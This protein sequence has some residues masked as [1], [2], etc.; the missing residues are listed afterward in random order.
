MKKIEIITKEDRTI[1]QVGFDD[2]IRMDMQ[3]KIKQLYRF[4]SPKEDF[5]K[6]YPFHIDQ[7]SDW[8]DV[9]DWES[10]SSNKGVKWSDEL[11]RRFKDKWHWCNLWLNES[12]LCW[13]I[14]LLEEFEDEI[15]WDF[16]LNTSIEWNKELHERFEKYLKSSLYEYDNIVKHT[17]DNRKKFLSNPNIN[18]SDNFMELYLYAK[19]IDD[20]EGIFI[21]YDA[22]EIYFDSII[23]D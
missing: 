19:S 4:Y 14:K 2:D 20:E 23:K 22:V 10:V 17:T 5:S 16:I 18:L 6:Y 15:V 9:L 21:L 1:V 7:L 8:I 13:D 12:I 11:I 3:E